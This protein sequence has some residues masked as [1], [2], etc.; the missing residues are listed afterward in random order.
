MQACRF[1]GT[2][3]TAL[4]TFQAGASLLRTQILSEV[5][6][7]AP[8]HVVWDVMR[9]WAKQ[10]PGKKAPEPWVA[11]AHA[12]WQGVGNPGRFLANGQGSEC[13]EARTRFTRFPLNPEPHWGPKRKH[14]REA[15]RTFLAAIHLPS[16]PPCSQDGYQKHSAF[17]LKA[18]SLLLDASYL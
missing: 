2:L 17:E 16:P 12:A 5:K 4:V 3:L 6:T 9:A 8:P 14:T 13:F 1:H 11:A 18:R 15:V 7:D 10:H